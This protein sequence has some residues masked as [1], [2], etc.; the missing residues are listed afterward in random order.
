MSSSQCHKNAKQYIFAFL[1]SSIPILFLTFIYLVAFYFIWMLRSKLSLCY[2]VVVVAVAS[3]HRLPISK[4]KKKIGKH[5]IQKRFFLPHSEIVSFL[6][7]EQKKNIFLVVLLG[8]QTNF[9]RCL[10]IKYFT[11]YFLFVYLDNFYC[12]SHFVG[13]S[14]NLTKPPRHRVWST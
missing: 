11:L 9:N 3:L 10:H 13:F 8:W 7:I 6:Y 14:L 4:K 1:L 5:T 2:V 12:L